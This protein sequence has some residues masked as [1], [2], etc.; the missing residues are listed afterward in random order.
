MKADLIDVN[1]TRRDLA[2][3]VPSEI[4]DE[5]IGH[6]AAKLGRSA[7]IPGFRPGKVPPT[8]IRQRFKPQIM[9]DVAE[10]LIAKAVGDALV[11]KGVE[12]IATPDIKD[13]V[14]EVGKPLTFK[15]TFD[16]VPSLDPGRL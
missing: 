10:H 4:V 2:I 12:P 7:R 16:G 14:H 15:A 3:E 5:A 1:E 11:E 9:Q 8:V 6:A 13:L